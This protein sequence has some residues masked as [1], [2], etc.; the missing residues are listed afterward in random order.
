M[1]IF[2]SLVSFF[3]QNVFFNFWVLWDVF[4]SLLYHIH[5]FFFGGGGVELN[6]NT[7]S[8]CKLSKGRISNILGTVCCVKLKLTGLF[9]R[10]VDLTKRQYLHPIATAFIHTAATIIT[11]ITAGTLYY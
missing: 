10:N 8:V 5:T 4:L 9:V 7:Q 6:N 11:T 1:A 3:F 2:F